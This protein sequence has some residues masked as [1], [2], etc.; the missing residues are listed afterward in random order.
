ML[1][2]T[3]SGIET[4]IHCSCRSS[5][6]VVFWNLTP[7]VGLLVLHRFLWNTGARSAIKSAALS[8]AH[9][10]PHC[11][12]SDI[13]F[14]KWFT[15]IK[16]ETNKKT[17]CCLTGLELIWELTGLFFRS[18]FINLPLDTVIHSLSAVDLPA[19]MGRTNSGQCGGAKSARG[20][21]DA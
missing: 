7:E 11:K 21:L 6:G 5:C 16:S 10:G 3:D 12:E 1:T 18:Y 8:T 17:Q 14:K 20:G 13:Y 15:D 19:V 4:H 2:Q 9:S